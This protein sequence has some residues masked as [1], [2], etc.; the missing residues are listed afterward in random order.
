[1][2]GSI[3]FMEQKKNAFASGIGFILAA[4]GSAVGL[5]NLWAFPAKT[6]ANGGAAFVLMYIICVLLIGFV[7]MMAEF[8]LGR[9]AA[10]NPV[11]AY[12]KAHKN[13]GWFGLIGVLIPAFIICYYSVLG[14][15]TVKYTL[16]S[17][18][19]N[20]GILAGFATN[21]G[22]VVLFTAIF[23]ILA[24]V[25]IMGG[26]KDGIE[27]MSKVLMPA[28]FL[29]LLAVAVY[30]LCLGEG[31]KEGLSFYLKPDFS[32]VTFSSVLAAMGQAFFS[33]SLGMGTMIAYGSYTGKEINMVK[34][35]GMICIFD[36]FV[37]LLSGL[38]IFPAVAHFDPSLLN[39][40]AAGAG[41]M[42]GILPAV[43]ASMGTVGQI[44]SFFFFAMV[45][46]AALTSVVSLVEVVTQFI[47]QRFKISRKHSALGCVAVCGLLSI[48]V[49]ISF[50]KVGIAE[51]KGISV[52]GMDLLSFFD[53]VTNTVL[54]P[55]CAFFA[56][57]AIGWIIKP[58]TAMDEMEDGTTRLGFLRKIYPVMVR[59][60]TPALIVIVEIGGVVSK[61][62]AGQWYVVVAAY[63]LLALAA[64]AYFIWFRNTDTGTNADEL[65]IDER[66]V[67]EKAEGKTE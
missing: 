34:S 36:T 16:N 9:R 33:L 23:I 45:A 59:Y 65:S 40:S 4:A 51:G 39:G 62:G 61:I 46:I 66:G 60:I 5:G 52:F 28:L 41:L 10:A 3:S 43:F 31:V 55:V 7:T 35:T 13:I 14:G 26:V 29:I 47:I 8:H 27:K 15:Y 48:P 19:G 38:A 32:H 42:F 37:A 6:A 20:E 25:I 63:L 54:M 18:S 50:G 44:V 21:I 49:G 64:A 17:F 57:V 58:K 22:E 11:S 56:C 1:M 67:L 30:S 53:E 24:L 12:K 2:K